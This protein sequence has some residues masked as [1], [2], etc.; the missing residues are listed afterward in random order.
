MIRPAMLL[1]AS[2]AIFL[3]PAAMARDDA[4]V[5]H[6]ASEARPVQLVSWDG[7]FE[8]MKESQRMRI[9]RSHIAYRL[10]VDAQ[11]KVTDCEMTEAFRMR[12]I[13]DSLCDILSEHH[14]FEPALDA[15]GNPVEGSYSATMSYADIRDRM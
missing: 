7:D 1:A 12:R 15:D 4:A 14:T 5:S 11:G 9:W 8:L 3:T 10:T 13:N 2:A 6:A